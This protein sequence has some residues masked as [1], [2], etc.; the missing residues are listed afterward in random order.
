MAWPGMGQGVTLLELMFSIF[1]ASILL[2]VAV[3]SFDWLMEKE[4]LRGAASRLVLETRQAHAEAQA[5][6]E[7][8]TITVVAGDAWC[9]GLS[10]AGTCDCTA[11]G[12]CRIQDIPKAVA[13]ENFEGITIRGRD[14]A[15]TFNPSYRNFP[16][17]SR[18]GWPIL[19]ES[20]SG[21]SLGVHLTVL[22][23]AYVCTPTSMKETWGYP[24]C[25]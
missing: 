11:Q 8:V 4:R 22:G 23:N 16:R 1:V 17:L 19:L 25:L 7:P 20:D 14:L 10:D 9:V 5:S 12:A 21:K 18:Q 6:G 24:E 2:T 15:T 13:G 3:P